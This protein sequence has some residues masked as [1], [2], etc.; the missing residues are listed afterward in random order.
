VTGVQTCALPLW[1]RDFCSQVII[2][3]RG[4]NLNSVTPPTGFINSLGVEIAGNAVVGASE[5]FTVIQRIEGLNCYDLAWGT[6][7][8]ATVTLSFWVRSNTTGTFGGALRNS[9]GDRSYPFSYTISTANTWEQK[10]ITI[11]GDTT[12]TWLTTNGIGI[13]LV[14]SLGAGATV[15]GTAGAWAAGSY[16]S[17]TGANNLLTSTSNYLYVTGVQLE[18]GS[19]ATA[20][21]YRPYGT[22]LSLC[23]RYYQTYTNP[24]LK[25]VFA[26][27]IVVSRAG[28]PIPNMRVAPTLSISGTYY[29]FDG[30]T[31][32]SGITSASA[33]YS[34]VNA[35]EIDFAAGTTG[36]C[37]TGRP[38][39]GYVGAFT[40]VINANAEL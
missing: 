35:V 38:A 37:V 28:M 9:A 30:T 15:S 1:W 5:I 21:D 2:F 39:I 27:T 6:A 19:T 13:N 25:G 7:N 8:A 14:F 23:Q 18:K 12:G 34:N 17:A 11:A 22:E 16:W 10:S 3:T 31:V 32:L 24:Q 26:S 40:S 29:F 36:A 20:F 33:T 4:Q